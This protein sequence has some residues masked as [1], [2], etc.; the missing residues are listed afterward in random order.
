MAEFRYKAFISYCH[1]DEAWAKWLH[2][3]LESYRVPRK[4]VG[5]Q[6]SAGEVAA[7]IR[8]VFRDRDDLSSASDLSESVKQV[9]A[10]SESLIVICSPEAAVSH[11]VGEEIREFARLGRP[12]RIFCMIVDGE[13]GSSQ[14]GEN[15]FNA[16]L[17]DVGLI[18]PLAADV[19]SWADGKRLSKLKLISGILG[20][21]LDE[22]CQRDQKRR[23]KV[24][25]F[26]G[27][28]VM[29]AITLVIMTIVSQVST[30][31]EREKAEQ[32]ASFIVDLGEKLRS[33]TDLE[34]LAMISGEASKHFRNLDPEQLSPETGKKVA[35]VLRQVARVSQ[36]QGKPEDA[37]GA[38]SKSRDILVL[39]RVKHPESQDILFELGIAQFYIGNLH[40]NQNNYVG[41][42]AAMQEYHLSTRA[43]LEMDPQNPDWIME[44]A[45]AQNNL[46][47]IQLDSGKGVDNVTLEHLAKAVQLMEKAMKLMPFDETILS[48]YS[49]TLAY[50]ADTYDMICELEK[51]LSIRLKVQDLAEAAIQSNPGN[52]DLK[53]RLAFALFGVAYIHIQMGNLSL[54]EQ[55]MMLAISTL[56]ELSAADP[57]NM[58]YR[59][60]VLSYQTALAGLMAENG[61]LSEARV[62]MQELNSKFGVIVESTEIDNALLH[63]YIGLLLEYADVE[64]RLGNK[65]AASSHLGKSMQLQT[66]LA[67]SQAL[68]RNGR[69]RLLLT[70]FQW[71]E[72]HGEDVSD[73]MPVFRELNTLQQGELQSCFE[74]DVTA[75]ML[76]L[77]GDI[78]NA[79][80]QVK[81]LQQKGYADPSF[82]RFCKKY[83]LSG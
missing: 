58:N 14:E 70:R 19:R 9:M 2:R 74:A 60:L 45:Y 46:A 61:H 13:P 56:E 51:A 79:V 35:L 12:S 31:H 66:T 24:A 49:N 30:R 28:G 15:C 54:G 25:A 67:N 11:W 63:V 20:I 62:L 37:L 36:L 40:L 71:W 80:S 73:S 32:M 64:A 17:G 34:T 5:K 16:A 21:R 52:N 47:A 38:Y 8:P 44:H 43:L 42:R 1:K 39:L 81:E 3:A 53:R 72:V 33:N 29:A 18:E 50:E 6:T 48:D 57:S 83:Q 77:E 26:A 55:N 59:R 78:E 82:I 4:L 22:L 65:D 23:R 68:G 69:A 75:R 41:A 7:R 76:L 10:E 27:L